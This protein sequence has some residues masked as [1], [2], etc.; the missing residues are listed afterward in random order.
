MLC[1]IRPGCSVLRIVN[2]ATPAHAAGPGRHRPHT[3]SRPRRPAGGVTLRTEI[4]G[5]NAARPARPPGQEVYA[6]PVLERPFPP[7]LFVFA[8]ALKRTAPAMRALI[9]RLRL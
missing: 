7:V 8:P 3:R 6:A 5:Q 2:R 4:P 1:E 9:A